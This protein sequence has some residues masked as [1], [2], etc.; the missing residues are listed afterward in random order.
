[1]AFDGIPSLLYLFTQGLNDLYDFKQKHPDA[2]LD[3]FL[4]KS[5]Q[6]FQNYIERGLKSI[7]LERD[8]RP[9]TADGTRKQ[10]NTVVSLDV[11]VLN[12]RFFAVSSLRSA[13][14]DV[15]GVSVRSSVS[16]A[17]TSSSD[18]VNA[19]AYMER[20]RMLRSRIGLENVQGSGIARPMST[21]SLGTCIASYI[22]CIRVKVIAT[23]FCCFREILTAFRSSCVGIVEHILSVLRLGR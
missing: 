18:D 14:T 11:S 16:Q 8:D 23:A 2:D 9:K 15:D 7:A 22:T 1:M 6:F 10:H 21:G 17:S 13:T 12:L 5:S 20:L 19:N 4:K 3:P